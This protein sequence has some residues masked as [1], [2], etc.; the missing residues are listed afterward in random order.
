MKTI[1]STVKLFKVC[2]LLYIGIFLNVIPL[3]AQVI[4]SWANKYN[5]PGNYQDYAYAI[6]T[7]G[8]GNVYVTGGS[9][10]NNGTEYDYATV[11]YNSAGV[12]QWV[13]RY[14]GPSSSNDVAVA[15][16]VDA[17]GNSY[18]TGYSWK[19]FSYNEIATIK[20]NSAGVQQWLTRYHTPNDT[21]D[22]PTA[23]T[24]DPT[25][26]VYVT[27]I[28]VEILGVYDYITVKYN[29]SGVQQWAKIYKFQGVGYGQSTPT[30]LV[31]DNIGNV[32]VT[33]Y[34]NI[35]RN[36]A[37]NSDYA[38]IKYNS[39]GDS[40]WVRRYA[41][42][43]ELNNQALAMAV[44]ANGNVYVTGWSYYD[45][46]NVVYATLKYNSSGVQQWVQYYDG[47]LNTSKAN[48]IAL[49]ASG[50]IYVTGWSYGI[51]QDYTTVKYNPAGTQQW[52]QRYDGGA[53]GDFEDV[54][55]AIAVD[56]YS[57]VYVTGSSF[58]NTTGND[59]AT[60]KYNTAGVQQWVERWSSSGAVDDEAFCMTVDTS[61]NVWVAGRTA[62]G[63]VGYDY[64][65]VKYSQTVGIKAISS[66]IPGS[67]KLMQN[68]PNPF[69][70]TTSI[71]YDL[72][73][74]SFVK[75]VVYDILGKEVETLVNEKQSPGTY[76]VTFDGLNYS[77]GVY[78]YKLT[79]ENIGGTKRM[80]LVK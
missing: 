73:K 3:K 56:K 31:V 72:P 17:S 28:A 42:L 7:D 46:N 61:G 65:T 68:Y 9:W 52:V 20:Y 5:G 27:G 80:M 6:A 39:N 74:N 4:Q 13:Q 16:A 58:G 41:G 69:N 33:G 34:S 38:T 2:F 22:S 71:R 11:K 67:F 40:L 64:A 75:L 15:I 43:A 23:I 26:N 24:I 29:S 66:E 49:D 21:G 48:A 76:E 53:S 57:N 63:S 36:S 45:A 18:V 79:G 51:G 35:Y 55:Y 50:N 44:D 10:G 62:N 25:G 19:S 14:D 30:A 37:T 77:S 70:P 1:K 78:Y 47:G 32:Y 12:Q 8:S 59:F 54:A 60:V